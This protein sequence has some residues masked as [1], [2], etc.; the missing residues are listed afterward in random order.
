MEVFRNLFGFHLFG[1]FQLI[2]HTA[3]LLNFF[4]WSAVPEVKSAEDKTF[5]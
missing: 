3:S 2:R 4:E 5:C 1:K